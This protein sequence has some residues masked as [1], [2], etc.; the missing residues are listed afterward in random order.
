MVVLICVSSGTLLCGNG[1]SVVAL[2]AMPSISIPAI[3][4]FLADCTHS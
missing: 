3:I 1:I 2:T 4:G